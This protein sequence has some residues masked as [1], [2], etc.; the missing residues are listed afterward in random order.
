MLPFVDRLAD[1][2]GVQDRHVEVRLARREL[3]EDR[4]VPLRVRD[5]VDLDRHVRA[6][7]RVLL[8]QLFERRGRR[9]LE[10][11]ERELHRLVAQLGRSVLGG[12]AALRLRRRH[13][14]H[15]T[16]RPSALQPRRAPRPRPEVSPS[17]LLLQEG[18]SYSDIP[19]ALR[20]LHEACKNLRPLCISC[21]H[22]CQFLALAIS[23]RDIV[24]QWLIATER[25]R[26]PVLDPSDGSVIDSLEAAGPDDGIAAVDAAARAAEDWAARA[27]RERA[28]DPT[29]RDTNL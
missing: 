9:P 6:G 18:W 22:L 15:R 14:R 7:L 27:P 10:P 26:F 11:Q 29:E 4:V 2:L 20:T 25:R 16:R 5:G 13:R 8:A 12:R 24:G 23:S 3:G 19:A 28:R 17:L 1:V 21:Q